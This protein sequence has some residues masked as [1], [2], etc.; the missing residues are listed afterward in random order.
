MLSEIV[1]L[2]QAVDE[3]GPHFKGHAVS[4]TV[5]GVPLTIICGSVEGAASAW[6]EMTGKP[7]IIGGIQRVIVRPLKDD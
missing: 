6:L 4:G 7:A 2:N 1:D 3:T 5:D